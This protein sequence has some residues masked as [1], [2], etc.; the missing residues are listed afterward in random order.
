MFSHQL[1]CCCMHNITC[2]PS[3]LIPIRSGLSLC[4]VICINILRGLL[5]LSSI[6]HA[7]KVFIGMFTWDFLLF[8]IHLIWLLIGI[9]SLEYFYTCLLDY[10]LFSTSI[11]F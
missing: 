1:A 11:F 8:S 7:H 5:K 10:K 9:D 3:K 4:P 2:I 6:Y